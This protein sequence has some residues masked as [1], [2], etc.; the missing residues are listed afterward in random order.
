MKMRLKKKAFTPTPP[1]GA[2][3]AQPDQSGK[4]QEG[5]S[6]L[7]GYLRKDPQIK[8]WLMNR[9]YRDIILH[10]VRHL[11]GEAL[12]GFKSYAPTRQRALQQEQQAEEITVEPTGGPAQAAPAAPAR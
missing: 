10:V 6:S 7:I 11:G 8:E 4:L 5:E 9:T 12:S 2:A 1:Q 3:P